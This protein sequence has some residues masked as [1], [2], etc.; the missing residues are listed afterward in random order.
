MNPDDI[1]SDSDIF[2]TIP[3]SLV[4]ADEFCIVSVTYL[5]LPSVVTVSGVDN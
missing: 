3:R 2:L 5:I 4:N 1:D